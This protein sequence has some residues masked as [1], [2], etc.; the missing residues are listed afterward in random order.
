MNPES[1]EP[2]V[3]GS[4]WGCASTKEVVG[5]AKDF[6]ETLLPGPK[7]LLHPPLTTF[8]DSP[9]FGLFCDSAVAQ[10]SFFGGTTN[11]IDAQEAFCQELILSY[12]G[13]ST[14]EPAT[15]LRTP[16]LTQLK[17]REIL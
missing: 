9:L 16:C 15:C 7:H 5:G 3:L 12:C 1:K 2:L 6:W 14:V 17:P 11:I 8:G 10:D 4:R 13:I